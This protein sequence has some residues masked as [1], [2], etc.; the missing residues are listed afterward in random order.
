MCPGTL[1]RRGVD[2]DVTVTSGRAVA[3]MSVA[4]WLHQRRYVAARRA[5][6]L[7]VFLA[8]LSVIVMLLPPSWGVLGGPAGL[9]LAAVYGLVALDQ[10][11]RERTWA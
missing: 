10:Y 9:V 11:L 1:R 3:D 2:R 6:L 8:V 7:A 5:L 4:A